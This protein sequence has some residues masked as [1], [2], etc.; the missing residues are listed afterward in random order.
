M[1]ALFFAR[2]PIEEL[3]RVA[4]GRVSQVK[5]VERLVIVVFG[6]DAGAPVAVCHFRP[7]DLVPQEG[8]L[9]EVLLSRDIPVGTT[10]GASP[11]VRAMH[12]DLIR[13]HQ[14]DVFRKLQQ[15]LYDGFHCWP[16][17]GRMAGRS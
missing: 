8:Q 15:E 16:E 12:G 11:G 10:T 7:D 2:D 14:L 1:P 17:Q 3:G 4:V 9:V 6:G 13:P 5:R